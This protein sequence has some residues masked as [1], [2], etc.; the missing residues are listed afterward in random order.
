MNVL[1]CYFSGTGNTLKIARE[2]EKSLVDSGCSVELC[3]MEKTKT[4]PD[5]DYDFFG[6]FYPVWAFNPPK[7]VYDF[8]K[9]IKKRETR[10]KAF[11][12]KSSG[13]PVRLI[14]AS[15]AKLKKMLNKKGFDVFCEYGYVMPYNI[16][17]RH[18]DA[19]AYR[20]WNAAQKIIPLDCRDILGGVARHPK[21]VPFGRMITAVM[22]IQQWGG[23][24][25]GKR[26]KT[27][28]DCIMCGKCMDNCPVGN[29][30]VKDGKIEFG[31]NCLMCM[32]CSFYCPKNAIKI[33]LFEKWKVN[34][35]YN[36]MPPAKEEPPTKHDKYCKKAYDRYFAAIDRRLAEENE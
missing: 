18:S 1:F 20:M 35:A 5:G 11:I 7:T 24:F 13:E 9:A 26:Y 15:S 21:R 25:N 12:A 10:V 33:G 3:N 30:S 28:E 27:T 31:K 23:R 19:A 36:F 16:I 32:R 4:L 2:Y 6:F 22:R 14:D 34:G 17:F 29:I 8:V